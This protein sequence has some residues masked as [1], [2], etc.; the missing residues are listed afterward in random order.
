MTF[1]VGT[2]SVG[3][4]P[5]AF[6]AVD[7]LAEHERPGEQRKGREAPGPGVN[8]RPVRGIDKDVARRIEPRA[9]AGGELQERLRGELSDRH[10]LLLTRV[11]HVLDGRRYPCGLHRLDRMI[12]QASLGPARIPRLTV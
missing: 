2:K 1:I 12:G 4:A 9:N 8:D 5:L 6:Q 10:G 11:A 3:A 7:R